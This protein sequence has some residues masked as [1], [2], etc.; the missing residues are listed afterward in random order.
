MLAKS[1]KEEKLAA[2]VEIKEE[3]A[4]KA[5]LASLSMQ[6]EF[7]GW[8][9]LSV[10]PDLSAARLIEIKRAELTFADFN[11]WKNYSFE[12]KRA[13]VMAMGMSR[14]SETE[15]IGLAGMYAGRAKL[16]FEDSIRCDEFEA[17]E[18]GHKYTQTE[19]YSRAQEAAIKAGVR[20]RDW[21]YLSHCE[22]CGTMPAPTVNS[23]CHWCDTF[24]ELYEEDRNGDSEG[25]GVIKDGAEPS[26]DSTTQERAGKI[27]C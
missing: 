12:G 23:G 5:V 18:G 7:P 4:I 11:L 10:R 8:Q 13:V 26:R 25:P 22:M 24:R 6:R 16:F 2:L 17:E 27:N 15:M 21:H 19:M 1:N 3:L 9:V 14:E 20:P